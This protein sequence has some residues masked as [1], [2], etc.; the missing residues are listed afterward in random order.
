[1]D[2]NKMNPGE[3]TGIK[4]RECRPGML[5]SPV[6]IYIGGSRAKCPGCGTEYMITRRGKIS[7]L[8]RGPG[9]RRKAV[10]K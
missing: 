1:M 5:P 10:R 4:C 9:I 6:I 7:V 2:T 3:R 8:K